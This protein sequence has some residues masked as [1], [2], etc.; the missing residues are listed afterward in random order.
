MRQSL[1]I[2]P[3][4]RHQAQEPED[5]NEL[6]KEMERQ[7]G[8]NGGSSV[9][10]ETQRYIDAKTEATRAQNDARFSE[11]INNIARLS[12]KID[13]MPSAKSQIVSTVATGFAIFLGLIAILA[14]AG[15]R[16]DGGMSASTDGAIA[17]ELIRQQSK[18]IEKLINAQAVENQKVIDALREHHIDQPGYEDPDDEKTSPQ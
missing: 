6:T 14:F 1:Q 11:V 8:G 12:D 15:D 7:G 17:K 18:D 5:A 16:F 3:I 10:E 9:D 2:V 4:D 13:G